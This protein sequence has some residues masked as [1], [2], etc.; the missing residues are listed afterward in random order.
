MDWPYDSITSPNHSVDRI[1][2]KPYYAFE[3]GFN[4]PANGWSWPVAGIKAIRPTD[5]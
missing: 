2:V 4:P 1:E 5:R 3:R